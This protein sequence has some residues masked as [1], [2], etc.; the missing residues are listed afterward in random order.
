MRRR[1]GAIVGT[2]SLGEG[3]DIE[4]IRIVLHVNLP[5]SVRSYAQETGRAGRDGLASRAILVINRTSFSK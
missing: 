1:H 5:W 3:L 4:N 2:T